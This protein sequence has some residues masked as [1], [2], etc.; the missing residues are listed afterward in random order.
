MIRKGLDFGRFC[1]FVFL[2]VCVLLLFLVLF[3]CFWFGGRG[4]VF[5]LKLR[6]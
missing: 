6:H 4:S 2:C 5:F 1:C 3:V